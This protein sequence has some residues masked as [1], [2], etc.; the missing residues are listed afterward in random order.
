M[1]KTLLSLFFLNIACLSSS[2]TTNVDGSVL[3]ACIQKLSQK[4]LG[5]EFSD[6]LS[7]YY[8]SFVPDPR[9][10]VLHHTYNAEER[11]ARK[12][13]RLNEH[14]NDVA[15]KIKDTWIYYPTIRELKIEKLP[16]LRQLLTRQGE[17]EAE[18]FKIQALLFIFSIYYNAQDH[19]IIAPC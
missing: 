11:L 17:L 18:K 13:M 19:K 10:S 6:Q 2:M 14:C 4:T 1:K 16:E 7:K 8:E 9:D 3:P 15:K 5:T 12:N